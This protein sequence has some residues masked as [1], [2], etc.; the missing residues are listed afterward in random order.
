MAKKNYPH[1]SELSDLEKALD[2]SNSISDLERA[3]GNHNNDIKDLE[4]TLGIKKNLPNKHASGRLVR[5]ETIAKGKVCGGILFGYFA[6]EDKD[7]VYLSETS[8]G[9]AQSK[10]HKTNIRDQ[11][12]VKSGHICIDPE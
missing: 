7:Y 1:N 2:N 4:R 8:N 11:K 6:G 10:V 3:L 5:I 9:P 12:E